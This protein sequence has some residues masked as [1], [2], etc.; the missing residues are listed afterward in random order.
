MLN[1]L[2]GRFLMLTVVFVM[3]AEVFI[4]VPSV[5]RFR[6][7][8]LVSRLERAQIASLALL[9]DEMID[10]ALEAELLENAEV[11]NVVLR[12]DEVRQL[13]L[14]S[15]IP[16]PIVATYD[17]RDPDTWSLIVDAMTT[18]T[19]PGDAIIRVIGAPVREGGELIEVTMATGPLRAAM[20]EYGLRVLILSA[21]ISVV[22]ALLLFAA[23]IRFLVAPIQGVVEAMLSYAKAPEDARR[24]IEPTAGITELRAA[25][26][27]LKSLQTQL[28][29]SLRQK[30]R[31]AQLGSGVAKISHDLR[32]TLTTAQLFADRI[33]TT[34]D[35]AVQRMVPKLLN[36]IRRAVSIC[37]GVLA[38]GRADEPPPALSH[39]PLAGIVG[40]VIDGERL[41]VGEADISFA[42]EVPGGMVVR[43]DPEQLFRVIANLV[44]NARQALEARGEGGEISISGAETPENWLIRVADTG[45][46]LPPKA[47]E[48]LFMPFHG[49]AKK[50]G[51]GLGLAIAAELVRG[52]GGRLSLA[53]T[54]PSGTTFEIVLPK[55]V[56][57]MLD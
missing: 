12:R 14:S 19:R 29:A 37:E 36:S 28:T 11:F 55:S 1:T 2:S 44:R 30:D 6:A 32:N 8:Y 50:G 56:V 23:V 3:L 26:E 48:H 24:I 5:A 45:P 57:T 52:H 34:G 10:P 27:A 49:A 41:A 31:L 18:L 7:E 16:S 4:F 46:G 9:A 25:E 47:Q 40:D 17:L 42:E 33:E 15:E 43:A 20:I 39:V 38:F 21:V 13:V 22:T 35:P 51:S 54:G 53:E